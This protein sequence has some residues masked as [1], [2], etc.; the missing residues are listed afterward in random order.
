MVA[1]RADQSAHRKLGISRTRF[2]H[3]DPVQPALDHFI[4]VGDSRRVR[5]CR[6]DAELH[7]DAT[8]RFRAAHST[9][10]L[11]VCQLVR[12]RPCDVSGNA[13]LA[14]NFLS[15]R[16][17]FTGLCFRADKLLEWATVLSERAESRRLAH[18]HIA[19]TWRADLWSVLGDVE[20]L[21]ISQVDL[22]HPLARI[23]AHIRNAAARIW[24]IRSIRAGAVCAEEFPVAEWAWASTK[25]ESGNLRRM[26]SDTDAL[27]S[28]QTSN[29]KPHTS[30]VFIPRLVGQR[31]AM[32][33]R[34]LTQC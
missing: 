28:N 30:N 33:S 9:D 20:L 34:F 23:L 25:R 5:N 6:A 4:C 2:V 17:D 18:C 8:F 27:Q 19:L 1:V 26:A 14:E 12:R 3:L 24:R 32:S 10:T 31:H 13:D 7:L 29:L 15:I 22:S 11:N 16:L 21:F